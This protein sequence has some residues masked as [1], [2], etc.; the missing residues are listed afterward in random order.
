VTNDRG[1]TLLVLAKAPS[2]GRVKTR[3]AADIGEVAAAR[4]AAACLLDTLEVASTVF[5]T[6]VLALSGAFEDVADDDADRLRASTPGWT[7]VDQ[8]GGGLGQRL[9]RAHR[10]AAAFG[11]P[12]LQ[13]GMDTPQVDADLLRGCVERLLAP[14]VDALLGPAVDGGWWVSGFHTPHLAGALG[15]VAMSR[16]DT[17]RRSLAT[18]RALGARVAAAPTVRDLDTL[19]DARVICAQNPHLRT[20]V[21]L[22]AAHAGEA[23]AS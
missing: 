1:V 2:P 10:D 6:R 3:L 17:G 8:S 23:K 7:V 18:L 5:S 16:P 11:Q 20:A 4:V 21:A 19:A 9:A 22:A 13:I 14:G 15:T 12:V